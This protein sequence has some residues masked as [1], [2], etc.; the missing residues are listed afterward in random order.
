M[1]RVDPLDSL[2]NFEPKTA[3]EQKTKQTN[4]Q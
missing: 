4:A 3:T 2:K 1:S